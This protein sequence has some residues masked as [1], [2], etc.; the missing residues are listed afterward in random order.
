MVLNKEIFTWFGL[1]FNNKH[2]YNGVIAA[3]KSLIRLT[4]LNVDQL[5]LTIFCTD[6]HQVVLDHWSHKG[7]YHGVVLNDSLQEHGLDDVLGVSCNLPHIQ[8]VI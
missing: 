3:R 8:R 2:F 6:V 5:D 1:S 4:F 7:A